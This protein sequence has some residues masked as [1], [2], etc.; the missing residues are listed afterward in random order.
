M[1]A[2]RG[3]KLH[4]APNVIPSNGGGQPRKLS[5]FFCAL[6]ASGSLHWSFAH[7]F[8]IMMANSSDPKCPFL[9]TTHVLAGVRPVEYARNMLVETFLEQTRCDWLIMVDED[10]V[11]PDNFWHLLLVQGVDIVSGLTYCWVGNNY[12]AGRLRVNQYSVTPG[13]E[14]FNLFPPQ[15]LEKPYEVPIVGTGCLAL[16]RYVLEKLP[17]NPFYFTREASGKIRG[18]EDINFSILARKNGFKIAVHPGVRFGHYK[19]VDLA[20][21][22][23]F[24]E[25][26]AEFRAAGA[27]HRV[28]N[29]LSV[30]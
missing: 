23:E 2:R 5:V 13:N 30:G 25:A 26:D 27:P 11:V 4:Q 3:I 17:P 8:G 20:Q 15:D 21:V 14:C 22:G 6:T 18:S 1:A 19:S 9:F 28:E 12:A 24:V 7:Q 16:R 10:Q 29:I